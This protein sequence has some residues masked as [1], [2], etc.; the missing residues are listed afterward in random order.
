MKQVKQQ[1]GMTLI[2]L[3]IAMLLGAVLITGV[4]QVFISSKQTN[5]L[6]E[7]TARIQENGRFALS[8][9][10]TD[11]VNAGFR[12]CLEE[13][14]ALVDAINGIDANR[15]N[16]SDSLSIAWSTAACAASSADT[17]FTSVSY[18]LDTGSGNQVSLYK[19]VGSA[20]ATEL[21]EDIDNLQFLFGA[22]T[23]GDGV[24]N[25]FVPAGTVGL[26][27]A[28]VMAVRISV[29]A[30]SAQQIS[31][32]PVSY[33]LNNQVITPVDRVIRRVFTSTILLRNRV[34]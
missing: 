10:S 15:I 19:K 18:Y 34:Q 13:G 2:E 14:F 32:R 1:L 11:L 16:R 9:I 33:L 20:S 27:M 5:Q 26:D 17:P 29:V 28:Q 25:Y 23:D 3:L 31:A 6:L 12:Q 30:R 7:A 4:V 22:D 8:F 21:V 24:P